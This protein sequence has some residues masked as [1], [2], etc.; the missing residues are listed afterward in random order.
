MSVKANNTG[1]QKKFPRMNLQDSVR[2][3][4]A[5]YEYVNH[6]F[7]ARPDFPKF[8]V[9]VLKTTLNCC[10]YLV[11]M[12]EITKISMIYKRKSLPNE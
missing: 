7:P 10:F 12:L 1:L 11:L 4:H 9:K 3:S 6:F 2:F 5:E 8:Y